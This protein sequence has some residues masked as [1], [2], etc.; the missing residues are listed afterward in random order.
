MKTALVIMAAGIGSRFGA[1]IKQLTPIGPNGEKIIDYSIHDALEAGFTDVVFIVRRDIE[2]LMRELVGDRIA[3][4]LGAEHVRYVYQE[5]EN[6]PAEFDGK[7][8]AAQRKKPWGTGQAVLSCRGAVDCPFAVINADD[9]YGKEGF[10]LLHSFLTEH[11]EDRG[12]YCM[13]GFVL[14]NTLSDFG[15][16]TRGIC[17]VDENGYLTDVV[18]TFD[19]A[20]CGAGAVSRTGPVDPEAAASMNMW[21]FTPDFLDSLEAGF[22]E[23][24]RTAE[25]TKGEY[26]LPS[27]VGEQL[28]AGKVTVKCLR[29]ED[30]W[31]GVTYAD[32][33]PIVERAIRELIA[34]GQYPEKL[35]AD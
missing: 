15:T 32:D 19:I 30:T 18:E 2:P 34:G 31:F 28:K 20:K 13:A 14:K 11:A 8:L 6:V 29:T 24:L 23:F 21:G 3:E 12:N 9:Y 4:R 25:L 5:L 22:A 7:A 35:W 10:R 26:L 16:V 33:K 17:S 27:V 1:G